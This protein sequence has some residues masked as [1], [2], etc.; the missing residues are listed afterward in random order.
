MP[1]PKFTKDQ[2]VHSVELTNPDG[3]TYRRHFVKLTAE[4][5]AYFAQARAEVEAEFGAEYPAT[6]SSKVVTSHR[7]P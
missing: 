2:I 1:A 7:T 3:R 5:K 4:Q 6:R